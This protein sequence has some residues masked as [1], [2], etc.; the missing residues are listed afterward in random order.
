[1]TIVRQLYMAVLHD[2]AHPEVHNL[3][4]VLWQWFEV[5]GF[6][7]K[8]ILAAI[9]TPL[10]MAFVKLSQRFFYSSVDLIYGEEG[11]IPQGGKDLLVDHLHVAFD[12]RFV[13]RVAH[14]CRKYSRIVVMGHLYHQG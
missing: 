2:C 14:P 3:K 13:F 1:M 8:Q 6:L 12:Q 10:E 7:F 9:W 4:R 11:H 5:G